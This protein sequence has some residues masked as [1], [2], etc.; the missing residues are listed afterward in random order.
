MKNLLSFGFGDAMR[1][2]ASEIIAAG[3]RRDVAMERAVVLPQQTHSANV[4]VVEHRHLDRL[5][6]GD[7]TSWP[8]IFGDTD[9]LITRLPGVWI[10]VRTADCVPVLLCADDI[11]AIAAIHAGWKGTRSDIVGA[12]VR[13]LVDMGADAARI[14]AYIG[15]CIC[16]D[17]Y[18]VSPELAEEFRAA[19][20]AAG[21]L[22]P[23]AANPTGGTDAGAA[24]S[25]GAPTTDG[26]QD[27]ASPRPHIDLKECNRLRLIRAG[28][29]DTLITISH[30]CT[31]HT[32]DTSPTG[33]GHPLYSYR[34]NPGETGRNITAIR[35]CELNG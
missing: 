34:R 21:V 32:T 35:L 1:M 6:N 26:R 24:C 11:R 19:G 23:A 5:R 25:A 3:I 8:E 2:G 33:S 29:S 10:G 16:A 15:P 13:R 7:A 31:R 28:V 30:H 14:R 12:T 22:Q 27:T 18:E 9:A 17:C 4:A 20:L